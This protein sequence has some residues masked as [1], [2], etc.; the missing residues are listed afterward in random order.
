MTR[1]TTLQRKVLFE[2]LAPQRFRC[3]ACARRCTIRR[4]DTGFCR[5]RANSD[6]TL[7]LNNY[8]RVVAAHVDT[9]E[10]KPVYHYR[11]GSK[12]LSIGT[13][14][15]NWRCDYCINPRVSQT[16]E[17][18]GKKLS[19][20]DVVRLAKQYGCHGIAYTYNE[21]LVFIEFARDIG[22]IAHREGLFNVVVS[23]GYGTPEAVDALSEFADC[24]TIGLKAN[25]SPSFLR[26]HAGVPS[27]KPIFE[28]LLD[29]KRRTG[30]HIE[31][32][33]LI[34]DQRG[35]SPKHAK[36]LSRWI[37]EQMGADTPLH[38][39]KFFPSHKMDRIPPA[40]SD[41]LE[42]H[43]SIAGE[44][45]LRYVYIANS[46]GHKRENT[47]CPNC[48]NIV[49]ARFGYSI[50]DWRLD[51]NN[52]CKNC[53]FEVAVVGNLTYTPPEERYVPVIF[54]PMDLLY[55]CEG[56]SG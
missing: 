37:C 9:I 7:L 41:V 42:A 52:R 54:P 32:S 44:A 53:G 20:E 19:P 14:G 43:C 11:P 25:A 6:G 45:G 34:L 22:I 50:N 23:N 35:D 2:Q 38:F 27:P 33:D 17:I 13:V 28:T 36:T 29:L 1:S 8:G 4:G 56:L 40:S 10:K 21:P 24:V 18:A 30:I 5:F 3:V 47:Y 15:C 51:D 26:K 48:G 31:I 55:V 12:L 46:P 16:D 49:I 39:V